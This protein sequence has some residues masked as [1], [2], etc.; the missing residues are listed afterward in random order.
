MGFQ[1]YSTAAKLERFCSVF[2]LFIKRPRFVSIKENISNKSSYQLF[3]QLFQSCYLK[4]IYLSLLKFNF[5]RFI[6]SARCYFVS[7]GCELSN[8]F[9][10]SSVYSHLCMK[11]MFFSQLEYFGYFSSVTYVLSCRNKQ[12]VTESQQRRYGSQR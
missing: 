4:K 5:A 6:A 11:A 8:F 3:P 9:Q 2:L 7:N 12:V 10:S 1:H